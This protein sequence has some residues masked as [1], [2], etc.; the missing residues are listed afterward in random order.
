MSPFETD[1]QPVAGTRLRD[2]KNDHF[3]W[4]MTISAFKESF[5][6]PIFDNRTSEMSTTVGVTFDATLISEPFG[7]GFEKI[8]K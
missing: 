5:L 1:W 4:K 2:P 3:T 6:T 7:N 8:L